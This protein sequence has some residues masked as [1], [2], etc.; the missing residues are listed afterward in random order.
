MESKKTDSSHL[1]EAIEMIN[2]LLIILPTRGRGGVEAHA[3]TLSRA[4]LQAN[5]T[6]NNSPEWVVDVA[7]PNL[8]TTRALAK[9]FQ[10][11]G[12][13][14]KPLA[15]DETE[16]EAAATLSEL[17]KTLP[18]RLKAWLEKPWHFLQVLAF[19]SR[20][21]YLSKKPSVVL[22]NLPW[23]NKGLT[24][25]LA[26]ALL[27]QTTA[28]VFHL[29]P[30]RLEMPK[31]KRHL[32]RWMRDRNQTWIA[33]SNN[34]RQILSQSFHCPQAK[35]VRI[36]NGTSSSLAADRT[37][38]D[39]A[40]T[41]NL[42][43]ELGLPADS[44]L[45]LTVARLNK[46]KGHDTLI[47]TIPHLIRQ[48]SKVHFVWAGD[49]EQE[50]SLLRQLEDYGI[51]SSVSLLGHRKDIPYLLAA[52]DLFVFPTHFEGFP[53]AL[54]EAMAC[55]VPVVAT[56]VNGI[57][58]IIGHGTDGLL[59]REG[60]SCDLLETLRW[61]LTHPVEM[62][63]MSDR[64]AT[65]VSAFSEQAMTDKTLNLLREIAASRTL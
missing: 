25:L 15:I 46:Q 21:R 10:A 9:D 63:K 3:L 13:S 50:E 59:V 29:I 36:Y 20:W 28:V 30:W 60:D 8:P 52:A 14:Y 1:D 2:R 42:R 17:I 24:S 35:I 5:R 49:G 32:Y 57:P 37:L 23:A 34:N 16:I 48:F 51:R 6:K 43:A 47:S 39:K 12:A 55:G 64:A 4:I 11:I 27:K 41:R 45:L 65:K 38:T 18:L 62:Q 31:W 53:F 19:L 44:I 40:S 7:L 33:I 22:I 61:A 56:A 26:C 54:L 58:E